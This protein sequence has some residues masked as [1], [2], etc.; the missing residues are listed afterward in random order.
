MSRRLP[1]TIVLLLLPL[2]AC[3]GGDGA[4]SEPTSSAADSVPAAST[5][6]APSSTADAS[7]PSVVPAAT[8]A[9]PVATSAE[10][11]P[12]ASAAGAA[13]TPIC[14]S[15]PPIEQISEIVGQP[16]TQVRDLS[17]AGAA[18]LGVVS[19]KCEVTGEGISL[20]I[21]ERIEADTAEAIVQA[22]GN[23]PVTVPG[24]DGARGAVNAMFVIRDDVAWMTT[25]VREQWMA[26]ADDP[27][28]Y[29]TSAAL[30]DAWLAVN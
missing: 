8:D 24:Y 13:A 28:A 11:E 22:A 18:A 19:E 16:L 1:A 30:L 21:F 12:V 3:G 9:Q 20:A 10:P 6:P 7:E 15:L 26:T 29:A 27:E 25:V 5:P 17:D 23:A 14:D 4:S 2:A